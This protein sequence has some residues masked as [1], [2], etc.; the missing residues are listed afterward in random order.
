[1]M[2][3]DSPG[4]IE[5]RKISESAVKPIKDEKILDHLEK[6]ADGYM[7]KDVK[8]GC[9]RRTPTGTRT[10]RE[11]LEKDSINFTL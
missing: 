3:D 2:K 4:I 6:I 7:G 8:L 1:M 10:P 5:Q 9:S 11:K